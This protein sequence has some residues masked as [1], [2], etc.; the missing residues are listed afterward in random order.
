VNRGQNKRGIDSDVGAVPAQDPSL[1]KVENSK[2]NSID[3][4]LSN[5]MELLK[6]DQRIDG[7]FVNK[8]PVEM[9]PFQKAEENPTGD[10]LH[11]ILFRPDS[12][13]NSKQ[14]DAIKNSMDDLLKVDKAITQSRKHNEKLLAI[15]SQTKNMNPKIDSQKSYELSTNI[16]HSSISGQSSN[17]EKTGPMLS[18]SHPYSDVSQYSSRTGS[19]VL[20]SNTSTYSDDNDKDKICQ[21]DVSNKDASTA[22]RSIIGDHKPYGNRAFVSMEGHDDR[23]EDLRRKN[24]CECSFCVIC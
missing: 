3:S 11:A 19:T 7:K 8:A 17:S 5:M 12:K 24:D 2:A 20:A 22:T 15:K 10:A 6:V 23:E 1:A 9:K 4:N 18:Q 21:V 14:A 16:S 13:F